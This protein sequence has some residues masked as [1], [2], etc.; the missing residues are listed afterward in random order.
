MHNE[1]EPH[2]MY[3]NR[4]WFEGYN[5]WT[6]HTAR[7]GV[8]CTTDSYHWMVAVFIYNKE[9]NNVE[10]LTQCWDTTYDNEDRNTATRSVDDY[11][12]NVLG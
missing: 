10:I 3:D 5:S 8:R 11:M 6:G 4:I 9:N 7:T 2:F 1:P 12:N